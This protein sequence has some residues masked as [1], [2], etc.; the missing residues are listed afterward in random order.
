MIP[1]P[2]IT[3]LLPEAVSPPFIKGGT[4]GIYLHLFENPPSC[5]YHKIVFLK[6]RLYYSN[7][8]E[9]PQ[10]VSYCFSTKLIG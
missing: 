10:G 9:C 3:M 2:L 6:G 7:N 4:G 5:T 1:L 8:S